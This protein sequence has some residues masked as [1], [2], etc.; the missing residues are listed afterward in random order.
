M[1]DRTFYTLW[2]EALTTADRDAFVSDWAL[3][4][5]WDDEQPDEIPADLIDEL[6]SLW[7]AAHTPVSAI[8]AHLGLTQMAFGMR[9]LIP[10]RTVENWE[11]GASKCPVYVHL[12]LLQAAGLYNRK[13]NSVTRKEYPK[14]KL[15]STYMSEY[16]NTDVTIV[17]MVSTPNYSI[18]NTSDGKH[19]FCDN[20]FNG[21][22]ISDLIGCE[23]SYDDNSGW[24][25]DGEPIEW[26]D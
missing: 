19:W 5:I 4:S 11:S 14:M 17:N 15:A 25:A 24:L 13:S 18:I 7:D 16:D 21:E 6:T 26:T 9:F 20:Q 1:T 10:T 23:I 22:T 3:S 12:L 8:R 2:A